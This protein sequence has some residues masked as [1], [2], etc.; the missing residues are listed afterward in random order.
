AVLAQSQPD[1]DKAKAA[2]REI[3]AVLTQAMDLYIE[4]R[5]R[6]IK[7]T[8]VRLPVVPT[9]LRT[10]LGPSPME[11]REGMKMDMMDKGMMD[12]CRGMMDKGMMEMMN[13]KGMKSMDM[14]KDK[15]KDKDKSSSI[16]Q[17]AK[18]TTYLLNLKI[19]AVEKM[20]TMQE[21]KTVKEG[22]VMTGGEMTMYMPG[23]P[24]THHLELEVR[25]LT[26]DNVVT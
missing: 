7:E 2:D 12:K 25:V 19:G 6:I 21:A 22:E 1:L 26:C 18:T 15:S 24:F 5:I 13:P 23:M 10:L 16:E 17:S 11:G 3:A 14:N 8:G 20:L 4:L 9:P